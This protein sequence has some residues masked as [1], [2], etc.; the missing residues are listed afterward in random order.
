MLI[1]R[2]QI[3]TVFR[4]FSHVFIDEYKL[5]ST[6]ISVEEFRQRR[7]N[8]VQLVRNYLVKSQK[9]SKDFTV[10]LPSAVLQYMGPDVVYFPFKQQADFY[11]LTGCLQPNAYLMLHGNERSYSPHLYLSPCSML[12]IDDYQRWFGPVMTDQQQ[13]CDL[14]QVDSVQ[15]VDQLGSINN[16]SQSILFYNSNN[17]MDQP[18]VTQKYF[19]SLLNQFSST[20]RVCG[21]LQHFLH[22]LRSIKSLNEQ[23]I[24][25]QVC[26][27][28]CETFR[29]TMSI[30][31]KSVDNEALI[32]A[33]FQYECEK[34]GR[35]SLAFYPVVAAN[36]RSLC[37]FFVIRKIIPN[38]IRLLITD[39]IFFIIRKIINRLHQLI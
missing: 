26:Q 10:C 23:N 18:V 6:G 32:K 9:S 3:Q 8:L 1:I 20:S 27:W 31:S 15:P 34:N 24:L 28:T 19:Q 11:Y 2:Q 13:I 33:R 22:A 30:P 25:R 39:Q 17:S 16:K 14:F 35:L 7:S 38:D 37:F 36:G 5:S 12:S 21:H 29:Q 4:R